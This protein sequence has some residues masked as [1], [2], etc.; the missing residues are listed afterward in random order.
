MIETSFNVPFENPRGRVRLCQR[1]EALG[2]GIG[3]SASFSKPIRVRI[4][5]C[6]SNRCQSQLV[7]CLHRPIVHDGNTQRAFALV[8]LRDLDPSHRQGLI[9]TSLQA[10]SSPHFGAG[11]FPHGAIHTGSLST[12]VRCHSFNSQELG[13]ERMGH[14]SLQGFHLARLAFLNSL[15]DTHL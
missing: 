11:A 3:A 12:F 8:F 10:A 5:G 14:K 13:V 1:V 2:N 4:S 9:A 15:C 6:L 7:E